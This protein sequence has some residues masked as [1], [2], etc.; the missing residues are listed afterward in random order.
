MHIAKHPWWGR[1]RTILPSIGILSFLIGLAVWGHLTHWKLG[2]QAPAH[3][4]S[5]HSD[6]PFIDSADAPAA[7]AAEPSRPIGDAPV[8]HPAARIRFPSPEA[9]RKSGVQ[10]TMAAERQIDHEVIANG[11]IV[12]DQT[13]VAQLSARVP[14]TVWRIE[15]QLGE[16]I[17]KGDVLAIIEAVDV[18]KAKAELLQAVVAYQLKK[19]IAERMRSKESFIPERQLYEVQA[20]AREANI[21]MRNAQ[22]TLVNFGLPLRIEDLEDLPD[23]ELSK[24]I[25][26]LG[27]PESITRSLDPNTTTVSLVPLVAPFDGVVIGNELSLGE[28]VAPSAHQFVVA[29]ISQMWIRLDV[30]REDAGRLKLGQPLVFTTDGRHTELRSTISWIGS[31]IDE[32]TRT[33]PVRAVIANPRVDDEIP[34]QERRMLL[35][36]AFGTGRI[37]VSDVATA[38]VVP[39]DSVQWDGR[40]WVV[41]AQVDDRTFEAKPVEV[42]IAVDDSVEIRSGVAPGESIVTIG[43]HLLKSEIV[44]SRLAT[45]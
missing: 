3:S 17:K 27:L 10:T 20:D 43:S 14:G 8:D 35:A 44:R 18:G 25:Q 19:G 42:G 26:F 16:P 24:R 13:R 23:A 45:N 37:R 7:A 5:A 41:F 4:A 34:G 12:Y 32:K 29:D 40:R 30:R 31:E 2:H 9:V 22:Q 38:T 33:A 28:V 1:L 39:R 6:A 21:R 15:K 11:A 36:N